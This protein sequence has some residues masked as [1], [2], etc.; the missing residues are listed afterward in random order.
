[1]DLLNDNSYIYI[2]IYIYISAGVLMGIKTPRY[3]FSV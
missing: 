3:L 2:Y 1:M